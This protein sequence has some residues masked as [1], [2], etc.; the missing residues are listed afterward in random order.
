[1]TR[2]LELQML[3]LLLLHLLIPAMT[4]DDPYPSHPRILSRL[5]LSL[6]R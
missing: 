4:I 3:P 1:M 6:A 5:P 2:E